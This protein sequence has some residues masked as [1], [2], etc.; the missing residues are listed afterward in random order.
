MA[1]G[2]GFPRRRTSGGDSPRKGP[3]RPGRGATVPVLVLSARGKIGD[4]VRGL[5][6]GA[7]D[8]LA[9][10]FAFEELLARVRANLRHA[11]GV[12]GALCAGGIDIDP[13][14]REATVDGRQV[15]LSDRELAVLKA[16]VIT[17]AGPSRARSCCLGHGLRLQDEPCRRLRGLP[18]PQNSA[19][20]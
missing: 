13:L 4:R 9:K 10:P 17:P 11:T 16:F 20:A 2:P 15:S 14:R 3:D 19:T 12:P 7:D 18:A 8:Y 1:C 6:L 5:N